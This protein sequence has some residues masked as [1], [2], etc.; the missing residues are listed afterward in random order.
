MMI[1]WY[2]IIVAVLITNA[3]T[4][5]TYEFFDWDNL[6]VDFIGGLALIVLFVPISIYNICFKNTIHPLSAVRFEELRKN[7]VSDGRCKI[8]HCFGSLYFCANPKTSRIW[9]KIFFL[10]TK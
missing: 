8:Y 6:W 1:S 9:N 5:L 7:W 3:I 10:R 4:A 2:W